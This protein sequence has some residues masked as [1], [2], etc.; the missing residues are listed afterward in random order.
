MCQLL[1]KKK[2]IETV[3]ESRRRRTLRREHEHDITV[4]D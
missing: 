3:C 4:R 2:T 1:K